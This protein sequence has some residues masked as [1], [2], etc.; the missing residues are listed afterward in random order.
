MIV[1]VIESEREIRVG[2]PERL[3]LYFRG[4]EK[5]GISADSYSASI[6]GSNPASPTIGMEIINAV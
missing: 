4:V 5:S 2:V 3:P 1:E 6:V